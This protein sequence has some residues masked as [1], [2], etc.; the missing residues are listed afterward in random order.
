MKDLLDNIAWHTLAGPH[1]KF[2]IGDGHARRYAPGFSPIVGFADVRSPDFDALARCCGAGDRFY[3]M[4]WSGAAPDGWQIELD[5]TMFRM[6]W[7]G[8]MPEAEVEEWGDAISLRPEHAAQAVELATLTRPGPFGP[9][10]P[11]LGEYF[12]CFEGDRL[13][14]MAGERMCAG[15]LREISGVCTHPDFQGQGLARRLVAK[16]IRRQL[17]RGE[18]PFL[19]VMRDNES[20]HRLYGRMG[21]RDHCEAIVRVISQR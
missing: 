12:G 18:T 10:T 8:S 6:V 14:A 21:F 16:L 11:E 5:S 3:C 13:I 4:D 1:S 9:R 19:H 20:A 7:D 17:L 15:S 2:A